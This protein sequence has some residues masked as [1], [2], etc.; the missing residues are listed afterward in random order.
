MSMVIE[1]EKWVYHPGDVVRGYVHVVFDKPIKVRGI[2]VS[3]EGRE[4]AAVTRGSGK[5]RHTYIQNVMIVQD[6]IN[7]CSPGEDGTVGP[8]D[9]QY[10]FDFRIP[11]AAMPTLDS[12]FEYNLSGEALSKGI[13][14]TVP[15]RLNGY[16]RYMIHAKVDRPFAIDINAK[17]FVS[18]KI[19]PRSDVSIQPVSF[20]SH[21]DREQL[22]VD[23]TIN[24]NI[25]APG[26][27][28][29][30]E[31]M[32]QRN[33]QKAVRAVEVILK[34]LVS[35]TAQGRTDVYK[36]FADD[37]RFPVEP[38]TESMQGVFSLATFTGGPI[39]VP[40]HIVKLEWIVEVK[41]DLPGKIDKHVY[42]PVWVIPLTSE[43]SLSGGQAFAVQ[44]IG[45][46]IE[47]GNPAETESG[48]SSWQID[49]DVDT[50]PS[51]PDSNPEEDA[52]WEREP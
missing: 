15:S 34:F 4:H 33:P 31:A 8:C 35:I 13:G 5:N 24:K 11:V 42:V 1:T 3:F 18:V 12:P 27:V 22:R 17:Q 19:P 10:P 49:A 41:V 6:T 7:V 21:D 2:Y 20:T 38:G 51:E 30:G 39:S 36:Q 23:I 46:H 52:F 48:E 47:Q 44:G 50:P 43:I 14:H 37:I 26:E 28:V 40:G 32:F 9:V 16:I 29:T 25:Y 45:W